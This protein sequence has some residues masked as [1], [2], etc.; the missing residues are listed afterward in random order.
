MTSDNTHLRLFASKTIFPTISAHV[1]ST[2]TDTISTEPPIRRLCHSHP[3]PRTS[4]SSSTAAAWAQ[5]QT[6]GAR[7]WPQGKAYSLDF[8]LRAREI[9]KVDNWWR[10]AS[11]FVG[12]FYMEI[13]HQLR[14]YIRR[15]MSRRALRSQ[16]QKK[17]FAGTPSVELP[18]WHSL[19]LAQY[20]LGG[21]PSCSP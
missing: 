15:Y 14:N 21:T 11:R 20:S 10:Y 4:L 13:L 3:S 7:P 19:M 6:P 16:P 8:D 12:F 9:S 18:R 5:Q 17:D 2:P 1:S